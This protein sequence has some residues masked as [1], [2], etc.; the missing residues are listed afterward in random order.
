LTR[1]TIAAV[2]ALL[3]MALAVAGGLRW[4]TSPE[5]IINA[6]LDELAA[7]I[8]VPASEGDVA[9]VARVASLRG[10]LAPDIRLAAAGQQI[11]SREAVIG[12]IGRFTAPPGGLEF[13]FVDPA[14]TIDPADR[15]RALVH[16]TVT[17]ASL[18][19]RTG[20]RVI[21]AAEADV[22]MELREGDWVI[23]AV[24]ATETLRRP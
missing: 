21:D 2:L 3:A 9:R 20:E 7:V 12:M 17:V 19:Q 4:W 24:E 18:D 6:R 11:V 15:N 23:A 8:S 13:D 1:K 14:V 22:T 10:Y 5:R 16:L